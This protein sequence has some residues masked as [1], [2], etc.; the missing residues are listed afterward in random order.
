MTNRFKN[1]KN[2][3]KDIGINICIFCFFCYH[4]K[5]IIKI[6]KGL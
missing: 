3:A 5:S 2:I 4:S 6:I 1:A